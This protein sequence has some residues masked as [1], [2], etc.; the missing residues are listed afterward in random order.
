MRVISTLFKRVVYPGLSKV[1]YLRWPEDARL[2]VL[3]Y[4]GLLP[5]GYVIRDAVLDGNL[6]TADDFRAQL[7]WLKTKFNVISPEQF[8]GWCEKRDQL[9]PRSVLLTGDDGLLNTL[10]D[11]LPIIRELEMPFLF[12]VT[13]ASLSEQSQ[14]LWYEQLFLWLLDA[15]R[16]IEIEMPWRKDRYVAE[17][18][19]AKRSLWQEFIRRLSAFDE[20]TRDNTLAQMRIQLGISENWCSEY[21]QNEP[22]RR[23]FFMLNR[24]ELLELARAG[25]TIG[26]HTH[27]HPMLSQMPEAQ[28]VREILQSRAELRAALDDEVWAL[29]YPFGTPQAASAREAIM[30]RQAGFTCAFM[31]TESSQADQFLYPRIHISRGM[32]LPELEAHMSG[33]YYGMR[34]K[35]STLMA[36]S[37]A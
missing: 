12:F 7:C 18:I 23:R 11:M 37:G 30:A 32:S 15:P 20:S 25:V 16:K 9:P 5:Q 6:I 26:A 2:A 10:T 19:S 13:G 14:M 27:S 35:Y 17:T 3:T 29:A 36:A 33:F 1:G 31:N 24:R 21:S 8:R 34:E 28:A 22:L 4:H